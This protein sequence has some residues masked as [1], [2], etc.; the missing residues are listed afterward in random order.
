MLAHQNPQVTY[1][2]QLRL[3]HHLLLHV[4]Q[5]MKTMLHQHRTPP[6]K[7]AHNCERSWDGFRI[8][9]DNIDKNVKPRDMQVDHQTQSLHYFNSFAVRD[10]IDFSELSDIPRQLDPYELNT[11]V[12]LPTD[13]DYRQIQDTMSCLISRILVEYMPFF[14][15]C[16][17]SVSKHINHSHAQ[18]MSMMSEVVG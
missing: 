2:L 18:E 12:F 14:G 9:G 6:E 1:Q 5:K 16:T 7:D 17:S 15:D 8:V 11:T 3:H 13:D 10:R 4:T